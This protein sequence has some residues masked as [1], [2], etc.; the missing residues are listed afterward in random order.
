MTGAVIENIK[1]MG[2]DVDV[3]TDRGY[4]MLVTSPPGLRAQRQE[5]METVMRRALR[6]DV[7]SGMFVSSADAR[8]SEEMLDHI[9]GSSYRA[10]QIGSGDC[11]LGVDLFAGLGPIHARDMLKVLMRKSLANCH[12]FWLESAAQYAGHVLTVLRFVAAS[13]ELASEFEAEYGC[14]PFSV[15]GLLRFPGRFDEDQC[16]YAAIAPFVAK[17]VERSLLGQIEIA[18]TPGL[19]VAVDESVRWLINGWGKT[20]VQTRSSVLSALN[21]GI[22]GLQQDND[23]FRK[24]WSGRP[25]ADLLGI[26]S[27]DVILDLIALDGGESAKL[28]K[29]ALRMKL[30]ASMF[31]DIAEQRPKGRALIVADDY[32]MMEN[33]EGVSG[34]GNFLTDERFLQTAGA[35]GVRFMFGSDELGWAAEVEKRFR[36]EFAHQARVVPGVAQAA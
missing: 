1:G 11:S 31:I 34:E 32:T 21:A 26:R 22:G 35:F 33:F 6:S 5:L 2:S 20:A 10:V 3:M 7:L 24:F 23:L 13:Q 30:L 28:T 27:Q 17:A 12:G 4:H 36:F 25:G 8:L 19:M 15:A 16:P 14:R 9:A 18:Y 29:L